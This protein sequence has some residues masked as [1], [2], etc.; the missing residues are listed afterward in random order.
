MAKSVRS[1]WKKKQ[2]KIRKDNLAPK[3]AARLEALANKLELTANGGL[4]NVPMQEPCKVYHHRAPVNDGSTPLVLPPPKTNFHKGLRGYE[5][6]TQPHPQA[7]KFEVLPDHVLEPDGS[8]RPMRPEEM[9]APPPP[10]PSKAPWEESDD[11]DDDEDDDGGA[12][13][14]AAQRAGAGG[15][16]KAGTAAAA[17][18]AARAQ[19]ALD[20][21]KRVTVLPTAKELRARGAKKMEK[22]GEAKKRLVSGKGPT[23]KGK[24][25]A[26]GRK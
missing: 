15:K 25:K 16:L 17:S 5:G 14:A 18:A 21:G 22:G 23:N 6:P 11:D 4:K 13:A 24:A 1:K 19:E 8:T 12:V 20:E 9:L 7:R 10:A 26:A 3:V 2:K